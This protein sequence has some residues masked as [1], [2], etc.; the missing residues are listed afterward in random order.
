LSLVRGLL[1]AAEH[2]SDAALGREL[3]HHVRAFVG[4][5]DVVVRFHLDHVGEGPSVEVMADL[6]QVL[7]VGA[8]L[9]ELRRGS[10]I[11]RAGGVAARQDEDVA[12]GVDAMPLTS[13]K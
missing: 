9:E 2:H 3:N 1:L 11:G 8:E 5:P 13:P 7:A 12:L 4:D 6:A 10:G